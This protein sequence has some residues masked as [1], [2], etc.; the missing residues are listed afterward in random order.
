MI[1]ELLIYSVIK[2]KL[3]TELMKLHSHKA[4]NSSTE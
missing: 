4:T 2:H 1:S 3:V